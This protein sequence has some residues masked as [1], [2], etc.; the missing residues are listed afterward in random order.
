MNFPLPY[1]IQLPFKSFH[2]T[3]LLTSLSFNLFLISDLSTNLTATPTSEFPDLLPCSAFTS[4]EAFLSTSLKAPPPLPY[5]LYSYRLLFPS[6]RDSHQQLY[7]FI[8]CLLSVCQTNVSSVRKGIHPIYSCVSINTCWIFK[9]ITHHECLIQENRVFSGKAIH[10]DEVESC[11][12][13]ESLLCPFFFPW[14]FSFY[15]FLTDNCFY[16]SK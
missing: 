5:T 7:Y 16:E 2:L 14:Y 15:R 9:A 1:F 11:L 12:S 4:S 6:N 3:F 13:L 10:R 8:T